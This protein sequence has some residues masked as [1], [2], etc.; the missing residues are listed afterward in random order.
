VKKCP[1]CAEEIQDE[2]VK[3]KHCQSD[4]RKL[5]WRGNLTTKINSFLYT[6]KIK[7]V[8]VGKYLPFAFSFD[9]CKYSW[10]VMGEF[11][12]DSAFSKQETSS[13]HVEELFTCEQVRSFLKV[14]SVFVPDGS[15]ENALSA[16]QNTHFSLFE[17]IGRI[18]LVNKGIKNENPSVQ[19]WV[20]RSKG[21]YSNTKNKVTSDGDCSTLIMYLSNCLVSMQL[22]VHPDF[23]DE[24][25]R[26]LM[27]I[28]STF[29]WT[30]LVSS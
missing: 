10:R 25:F 7:N 6:K 4:I 23:G 17:D 11:L 3:C 8:I 30:N 5:G 18:D 24:A 13:I 14:D 1:F 19:G 27:E 28:A 15:I 12:R 2:A 21:I 9:N 26:E 16:E 29:R 20:L 22:T